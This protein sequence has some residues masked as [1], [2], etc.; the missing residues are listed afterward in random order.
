MTDET[1]TEPVK[2]L[3]GRP[4][5]S[6]TKSK[7]EKLLDRLANSRGDNLTRI[8]D[9][10]LKL[11][12]GGEKWA[13]GA[14]MDRTWPAPKGRIVKLDLPVGLGI[15]GIAAAFDQIIAAVNEGVITAAEALDYAALLEKQA[16]MLERKDVE[17]RLEALE[18]E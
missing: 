18:R 8:V 1:N 9:G 14:I 17:K 12:E 5:G 15:D 11:A 3:G 4:K 2:N 6:R 13:A 10:V 7:T 16:A